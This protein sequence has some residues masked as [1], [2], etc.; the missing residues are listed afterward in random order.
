MATITFPIPTP[1]G[2]TEVKIPDLKPLFILGRNGT[3]K[4]ALVHYLQTQSRQLAKRNIIYIPGSRPSYFEGDSLN[5][6]AL[7]RS[8]FETHSPNWDS[9]PDTRIRPISGTSR[10]ERA[11]FDLQA[12]EVQYRVE[13]ANDIEINGQDSP[14][15]ALLQSKSSPLDRVN[16][17]LVQANLPIQT[18]ISS[19]EL[20]AVR[21]NATYSISKM[22]DGERIALILIADVISAKPESI[23]LIDEPELH[24]HRAIIV[25]LLSALIAE[26]PDCTMIIS[27]HEL[28]LTNNHPDS[29]IILV[30]GCVWGENTPNAWD[31]EVLSDS[32]SIPS[33]LRVD[34]LGSRQ[35]ILFIEGTSTSRDQ[36]IYATLFPNISLRHR[37][38]CTDV[39]RAVVGLRQ[40][41]DFHHARAFGL[42]DNDSMDE[43]F[44]NTLQDEFVYALPVFSVESFYY[45]HEIMSAVAERQAFTFQV[46]STDLLSAA[47]E[48]ALAT[49]SKPGKAEHLAARVAERR[50]RDALLK[51]IPSREEMI[52]SDD[53]DL[54]IIVQSPYPSS[55]NR[56]KEYIQQGDLSSI[57]SGFPVRESGILSDISKGLRFIGDADYE[58]AALSIINNNQYLIKYLKDKLGNLSNQLEQK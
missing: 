2:N 5:M 4:S 58:R 45:D 41:E 53:S 23:L 40:V 12:A 55:L 27:T 57:I 13:A 47:K 10:N 16:R 8:Q 38:S 34:L 17:L 15:I 33:D 46:N 26:R 18:V 52:L 14:A 29:P 7:A 24:L 43:N 36:P 6:N 32:E 9:S 22:S 20:K 1:Q 48:K 11:I 37:A 44:I 39:R 56:I 3:G 50:M 30:R 25:P 28:A 21:E 35:T 51:S 31:V 42:V 49:L 19:G 54:E